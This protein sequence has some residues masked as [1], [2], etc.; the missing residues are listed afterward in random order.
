MNCGVREEQSNSE[1]AP[2]PEVPKFSDDDDGADFS[3]L[4]G[5]FIDPAHERSYLHD[6]VT[7][8]LRLYAFTARIIPSVLVAFSLVDLSSLGFGTTWAALLLIRCAAAVLVLFTRQQML[9]RPQQVLA[10]SPFGLVA[11]CQLVIYAAML[12]A[13][14]LRPGDAST[15]ALSVGVVILGT[16]V[17]VPGRFTT[18]VTIGLLAITGVGVVAVAA[19]PTELPI[20]PLTANLALALA[21]G[22]GVRRMTGRDA[23]RRWYAMS[24]AEAANERLAVELHRSDTLRAELQTLAERDPLTSAANRREFLRAAG[25]MLK[26]RR[27]GARPAGRLSLL[28]IDADRFKAINDTF[29]HQVGDAALVAM[30]RSATI[31][32][33]DQDIV[34]RI[35]GE[36]FAVLLPGMSIDDA[37]QVAER[38][39]HAIATTCIPSAQAVRLTASVG[40]ATAVDA[41][42]VESLLARADG[43]MYAAKRAGG[44]RVE[45]A[46]GGL[47]S[48]VRQT[49]TA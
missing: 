12:L 29:G 17:L 22:L 1:P 30:T 26:D 43:A 8:N 24:A 33:R 45:C 19:L 39:R 38:V 48:D 6:Q 47:P 27:Q 7:A 46:L 14:S 23:R 9:R 2:L 10:G 49:V 16:T 40:V 41:D 5:E 44:D 18:Q 13:T 37:R 31:A 11:S 32:V 34:A 15:S 35:G 36:E 28:L 3:R 25:E 21:F 20:V 4:T 42:D